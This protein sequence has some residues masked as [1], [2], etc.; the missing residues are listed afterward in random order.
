VK[1]NE[2][3][4]DE[5][6]QYFAFFLFRV[7][8]KI[9]GGNCFAKIK[10]TNFESLTVWDRLPIVG[11]GPAAPAH[12]GGPVPRHQVFLLKYIILLLLTVN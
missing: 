9:L 5:A 6:K 4:Y 3:T 12:L 11:R 2:V 1:I 8:S 10:K 7:T